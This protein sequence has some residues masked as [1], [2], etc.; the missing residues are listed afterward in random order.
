MDKR[1]RSRGILKNVGLN[2]LSE[3]KTIRVKAHGYSMYPC[4]KPGATVLIEPLQIKGLPVPGEIIAI[5]RNEGL[6]VHRLIK[7][8]KRNGTDLYIARGDSNSRHD[9]PVKISLIA[10]RIIKAENVGSVKQA[11]T[12]INV[13]PAHYINRMKVI[14]IIISQRIKAAKVRFAR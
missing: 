14:L 6:I 10:G 2:L 4:I 12:S 9:E 7:I 5:K 8:V 11:D 1:M 13:K 3:G